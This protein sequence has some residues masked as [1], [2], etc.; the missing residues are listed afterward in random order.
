[1]KLIYEME[2]NDENME[3]MR[4]NGAFLF[5]P[6]GVPLFFLFLIY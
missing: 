2:K 3:N 1:M 5:F 4:K 6:P